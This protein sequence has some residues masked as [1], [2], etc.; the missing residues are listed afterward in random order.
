MRILLSILGMALL[1]GGANAAV[2][3]LYVKAQP[4]VALTAAPAPDAVTVRRLTPGDAL[5]VVGRQPGFVNVQLADGVQGWLRDAD[6]TN[7]A[8]PAQR[9]ATLEQ[10][11]AELRRQLA[12]A[13]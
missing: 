2:E 8:P 3:T 4:S 11:S 12:A 9:V 10:E 5:T 13:Q 6:V 7:T 1:S